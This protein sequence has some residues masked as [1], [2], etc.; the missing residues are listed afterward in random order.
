VSNLGNDRDAAST[1]NYYKTEVS[2]VEK[3]SI[4]LITI[5]DDEE[6]T[7]D[8]D[9]DSSM[10]EHMLN[11]RSYVKPESC[12]TTMCS[13]RAAMEGITFRSQK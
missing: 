4:K 10:T 6:I 13:T 2:K 11:H 7:Q 1:S 12:K 9:D 3:A 8:S 5:F